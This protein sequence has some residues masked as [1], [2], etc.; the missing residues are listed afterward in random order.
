[1]L[2]LALVLPGSECRGQ[3]AKWVAALK[4]QVNPDLA[5]LPEDTWKLMK[6]KGDEFNHPKTEVGLVYD[7]A[8]GGVIY[9][10]G[11]SQGYCNTTWIYHV[12]SDTW[13]EVLPWVKGKEE[14]TGLPIGQCGY[15]AVYN[16]D[17]GLYFK[18]RGCSSTAD[19]RGGRGRDSNSWTLDA[20]NLTWTRVASGPHEGTN[21]GW[22]GAF[23]C[24]GMV[25]DRDAK[26]A[27][28]YSGLEGEGKAIWVFDFKD[29]KWSKRTPKSGPPALFLHSMVYDSVNKVTLLFGGQTGGYSD[30]RTVN[31]TWAYH[32]KTNTWE[33]RTPSKTPP[34]R[35]QAQACFDTVNGVMIVF[36]GHANVYPKRA[37]GRV[38]SDTWV[39][40]YKADTWTEMQPKNFPPA[41]HTLR[42]MA[43]DPVN[44]VAV[45]VMNAG[46]KKQTWVYRFRNKNER[47]E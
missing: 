37:D 32:C 44:N 38:F 5:K 31:D 21:A 43:F 8:L 33:K 34:A 3:P 47:K 24:Y 26:V 22:P 40:D 20:R 35:V 4:P 27:L 41:G 30:G 14:D 25:Y 10:G 13:K 2:G 9:F 16:N 28:L 12:G 17:L 18:H 45:N 42:F 39:Y 36:G 11:C 46:S 23:C 6:P 7:E 1:L 29:K 15:V 19:G